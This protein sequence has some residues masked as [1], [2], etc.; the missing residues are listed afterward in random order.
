MLFYVLSVCKCVLYYCHQVSTQLQLKYV[1]Y[2]LNEKLYYS[3]CMVDI[4]YLNKTDS[5]RIK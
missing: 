4:N 5:I 1:I 2:H 3:H